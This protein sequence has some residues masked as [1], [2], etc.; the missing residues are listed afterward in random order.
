MFYV[1]DPD[2][3]IPIFQQIHDGVVEGILRGHLKRGDFLYPV[4]R[5][6]VEFGVNPATVKKAYDQLQDEGLV[7]TAPRSGTMVAQPQKP[8]KEHREQLREDL[9]TTVNRALAQG[10]TRDDIQDVIDEVAI[11]GATVA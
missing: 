2:S 10:F 11:T 5:V 7:R 3:R 9:K 6:A 8:T 4:R 1:I